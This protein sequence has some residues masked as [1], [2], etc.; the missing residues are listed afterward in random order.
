MQNVLK[1]SNFSKSFQIEGGSICPCEYHGYIQELMNPIAPLILNLC[2]NR[3][4]WS[5]HTHRHSP[6]RSLGGPQSQWGRCRL[7]RSRTTTYRLCS[8]QPV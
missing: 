7:Q 6:D 2:V 5:V 3:C 1:Q 4:E 8:R